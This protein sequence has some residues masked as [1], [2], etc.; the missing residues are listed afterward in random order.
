MPRRW[1][2]PV[3][4][5]FL[6]GGL[7][8]GC[9]WSALERPR[10]TQTFDIGGGRTLTVWSVRRDV[11][12]DFDTD[13]NPLMVHYRIDRDGTELVPTTFL[14]HDDEGSYQFN[15]LV[16]EGGRLVCAY[17]VSRGSENG[18]MTI[19]YDAAS[20]ESWPRDNANWHFYPAVK[21]KWRERFERVQR[22][23][24]G[25]QMPRGLQE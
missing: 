23:H 8:G 2:V 7:C 25:Y 3:A 22:E 18:Y 20:G 10:F 9:L 17:E 11:L 19:L 24:P 21:R 5:L 6:L 12:L 15:V 4:G 14:D 16:A 13:P 1:W